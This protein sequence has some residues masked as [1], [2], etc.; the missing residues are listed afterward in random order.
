MPQPV[1]SEHHMRAARV[2]EPSRVDAMQLSSGLCDD[3]GVAAPF[4]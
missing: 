2:A 4:V 3:G 1:Q